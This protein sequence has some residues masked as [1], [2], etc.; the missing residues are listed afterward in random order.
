MDGDTKIPWPGT[1]LGRLQAVVLELRNFGTPTSVDKLVERFSGVTLEQ[2]ESTLA[3]L[4]LFG[5][6]DKKGDLFEATAGD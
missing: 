5:R 2:M 1:Y 6:V 4:V 3:A